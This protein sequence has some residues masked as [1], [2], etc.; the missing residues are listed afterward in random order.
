MRPC[1]RASRGSVDMLKGRG[2]DVGTRGYR[3]MTKQACAHYLPSNAVS[4]C[5]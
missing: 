4:D 1:R 2:L 3:I 5:P